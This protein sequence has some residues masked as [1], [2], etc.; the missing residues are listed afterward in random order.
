MFFI[1]KTTLGLT[2]ECQSAGIPL[3]DTLS[4]ENVQKVWYADDATA[5][6]WNW[7][8]CMIGESHLS[9]LK[10]SKICV[11]IKEACFD[12]AVSLFKVLHNC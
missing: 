6:M 4:I 11:I 9:H 10:P 1:T 2:V 7:L 5:C 8:M 12:E 3:I